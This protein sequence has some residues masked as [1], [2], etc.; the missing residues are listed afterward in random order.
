MLDQRRNAHLPSSRIDGKEKKERKKE[1][2]A[3]V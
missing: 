3:T 2:E 1:R